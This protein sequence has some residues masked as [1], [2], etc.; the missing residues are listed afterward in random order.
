MK[1]DMIFGW[2]PTYTNKQDFTILKAA[3][4]VASLDL[5]FQEPELLNELVCQ[6]GKRRPL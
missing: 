2:K 4:L 5:R 3:K 1:A 6:I